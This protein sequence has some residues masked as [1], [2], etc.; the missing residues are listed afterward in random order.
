MPPSWVTRLHVPRELQ[1][2][3]CPEGRKQ[4]VYRKGKHESFAPYSRED[5]LV[6]QITIFGDDERTEVEEIMQIFANRKDKLARRVK[7]IKTNCIHEFFEPGRSAP[8]QGLKEL[9]YITGSRREFHFYASARLDGGPPVHDSLPP[10]IAFVTLPHCILDCAHHSLILRPAQYSRHSCVLPISSLTALSTLALH[11]SLIPSLLFSPSHS[12]PLDPSR[13]LTPYLSDPFT[14]LPPHFRPHSILQF[15][16]LTHGFPPV[17]SPT[18]HTLDCTRPPPST[19]H[20]SPLS[21]HPPPVSPPSHPTLLLTHPSRW[22]LPHHPRAALRP[23]L[24]H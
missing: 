19:Q 13:F 8:S 7:T 23:H 3:R 21:L 17:H 15:T 20:A 22:Q 10:H 5:G 16:S 9:V 6:E 12:T 4:V 2:A 24:S 1:Q 14:T 11:T 18:H